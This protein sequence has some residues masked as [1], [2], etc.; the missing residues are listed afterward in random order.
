M[1]SKEKADELKIF[2]I[3][4]SSVD[5]EVGDYFTGINEKC[6]KYYSNYEHWQIIT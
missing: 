5:I 3:C 2:E 1:L 6:M 4:K